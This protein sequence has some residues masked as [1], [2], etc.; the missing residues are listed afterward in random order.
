MLFRFQCKINIMIR[1]VVLFDRIFFSHVFHINKIY[2]RK[3]GTFC[4]GTFETDFIQYVRI[5][6]YN[7]VVLHKKKK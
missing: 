1:S 7:N 3:V 4:Y 6:L 5:G 2:K